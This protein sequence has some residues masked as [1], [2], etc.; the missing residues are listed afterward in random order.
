MGLG[1]V[2]YQVSKRHNKMHMLQYINY[3]CYAKNLFG[4][5]DYMFEDHFNPVVFP[6]QNT[7]IDVID[8][9]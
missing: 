4:L 1:R 7:I 2:A 6:N 3:E 8:Y 5:I 9:S